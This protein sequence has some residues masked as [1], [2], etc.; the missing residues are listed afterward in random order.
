L[1]GCI[2]DGWLYFKELK[3][4]T[5]QYLY[6]VLV[7]LS[8]HFLQIADGSVQKNLNIHL[9][10]QQRILVP[11]QGVSDAFY[12]MADTLFAR[13]RSNELENLSLAALRD[14]LLPKLMSGDI[15]IRDPE[16]AGEDT[17]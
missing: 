6:H 2:H 10:G 14:F 12:S 4:V 16:R 15:R 9:V 3:S 8:D 13:M 7:E 5:K 11:S 1:H 17:V